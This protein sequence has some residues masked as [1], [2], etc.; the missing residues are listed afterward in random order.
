MAGSTKIFGKHDLPKTGQTITRVTGDDGY[1][2]KGSKANPRFVD[3]GDG[4][5]SDRVTR[6]MWVKDGSGAGCN[7]GG[8]LSFDNAIAFAE[9]LDF[10]GHQ[11]WRMPN[12]KELFS[13]V[14][15]DRGGDG[16]NPAIDPTFFPNTTINDAYWTSTLYAAFPDDVAWVVNFFDGIVYYNVR[17]LEYYVRPCRQY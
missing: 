1:Y 4:T 14:D 13:I 12:V 15:F 6:L 2:Q 17:Y 9:G 16:S 11:D 7:N 8:V 5:I 3:N 10:A